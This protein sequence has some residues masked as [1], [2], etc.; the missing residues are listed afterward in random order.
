MSQRARL[1]IVSNANFSDEN[2][3]C[4]LHGGVE[5]LLLILFSV[6]CPGVNLSLLHIGNAGWEYKLVNGGSF[7]GV[8]HTT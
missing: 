8:S 4:G 6:H 3:A 5:L 7:R 1:K 2:Q